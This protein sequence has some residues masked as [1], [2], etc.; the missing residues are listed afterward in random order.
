MSSPHP[1]APVCE[2][3]FELDWHAAVLQAL[4]N[5]LAE[6]DALVHVTMQ[7][8]MNSLAEGLDLC[9]EGCR[10]ARLAELV[11]SLARAE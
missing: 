1:L 4:G 2:H 10:L 3:W 8:N 5:G 11:D 6:E 9:S 7:H